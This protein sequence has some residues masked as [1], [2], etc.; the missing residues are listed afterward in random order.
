MHAFK[1]AIPLK[2]A[3]MQ[4]MCIEAMRDLNRKAQGS[5]DLGF[6]IYRDL[7]VLINFFRALPRK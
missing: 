7:V 1:H 6:G 2:R 3:R 5:F 4:H